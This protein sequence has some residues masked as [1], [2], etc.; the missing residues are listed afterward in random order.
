MDTTTLFQPT[1]LIRL[2]PD[3]YVKFD[4]T[5]KVLLQSAFSD[6]AMSIKFD[7]LLILYELV[8][9]KSYQELI[10]PWPPEDQIKIRQYLQM[11]YDAQMLQIQGVNDTTGQTTETD[12]DALA[13]V[14]ST[15]NKVPINVE[16]HFNM[17]K[18]NVRMAAYRRAI[19]RTVRPGDTVLDIGS[20]SGVLSFFASR[21]GA[22]KVIGIERQPH[23][24]DLAEAL[25][26][27]NGITNVEFH[28]ALSTQMQPEQLGDTLP[29]VLVSEI[30][31]DGI[32]E[33]NVLE[34]TLDARKRLLKP[35]V[36]MVPQKLDIYGFGFY[37][38]VPVNTGQEVE[39]LKDLY[40]IDFTL[41]GQVLSGKASLRRER[42]HPQ[43]FTAMTPPARVHTLDLRTFDEAQFRATIEL[44]SNQSGHLSGI[45]LYFKAWLDESTVLTNSPWSATT[46]WHHLMYYLP[47][48]E[49]MS[50]GQPFE[51][52]LIY[53]GAL[54]VSLL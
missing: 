8:Q 27:A 24:A 15:Y 14:R 17:L 47:K 52:E 18:D 26:Q 22:A 5:E 40:G 19:E 48:A 42:Y 29:N 37:V 45:C 21:A 34:Y 54:R 32:L 36:R 20:G 38:D 11:F 33:E 53:D 28:R 43:L 13:R 23:I 49:Q 50:P 44:T 51:A 2:A 10:T 39:E 12:E 41:L 31:G 25:A 3:T 7:I 9:W 1:S 4:G 6:Q 35:G 30:L 16:N 46:H